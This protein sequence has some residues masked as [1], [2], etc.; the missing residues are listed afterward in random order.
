MR[1]CTMPTPDRA[2]Q[3]WYDV[4]TDDECEQVAVWEGIMRG[5]KQAY[6][7]ASVSRSVIQKRAHM[8]LKYRKG[9]QC[10]LSLAKSESTQAT[11]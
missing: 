2:D 5:A 7:L 11:E 4:L 8:R 1:H 6:D 10:S 3:S 9:K